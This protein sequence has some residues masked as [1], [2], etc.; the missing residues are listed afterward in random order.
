MQLVKFTTNFSKNEENTKARQK[1]G[2]CAL[3]LGAT[4]TSCSSRMALSA[5]LV[6]CL[7]ALVASENKVFDLTITQA[8]GAPDG[9]NRYDL[10]FRPK[11]SSNLAF[12]SS[13]T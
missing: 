7:V 6:L 10:S 5:L 12:F 11:N 4:Y 13:G 2:M 3:H 9:F 1:P 8:V